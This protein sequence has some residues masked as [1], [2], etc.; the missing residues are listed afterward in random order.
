MFKWVSL[1]GLDVIKRKTVS[2]WNSLRKL[3]K[4][5]RIAKS[6]K[7]TDERI[8]VAKKIVKVQKELGLKP[9][10]FPELVIS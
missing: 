1:V 2:Q 10:V 5:Y 7:D 4:R 6:Q 8:A 3:W 9:S